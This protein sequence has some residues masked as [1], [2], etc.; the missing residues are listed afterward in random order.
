MDKLPVDIFNFLSNQSYHLSFVICDS[1]FALL[2]F[3][4]R[5]IERSRD[6]EREDKWLVV[7][8]SMSRDSFLERGIEELQQWSEPQQF[9]SI[10]QKSAKLSAEA[11]C[12]K[13]PLPPV[14]YD[15]S[16]STAR[17]LLLLSASLSL[18]LSHED[19]DILNSWKQIKYK[20][21]LLPTVLHRSQTITTQPNNNH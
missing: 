4:D 9:E 14:P 17:L 7:D 19:T 12:C 20:F 15:A 5:E 21:Y 1:Q 10:N 11:T 16:F 3:C 2:E 18:S 6:R 13:P 8:L